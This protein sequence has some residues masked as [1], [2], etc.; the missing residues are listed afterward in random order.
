MERSALE[1]YDPFP[2]FFGE[3]R[4]LGDFS[5]SFIIKENENPNKGSWFK[6]T[7]WL[8]A[9]IID[10]KTN[11]IFEKNIDYS[12]KKYNE[13]SYEFLA[14]L[15]K[16]RKNLTLASLI[17]SSDTYCLKRPKEIGDSE[18]EDLK[19]DFI[20]RFKKILKEDRGQWLKDRRNN[21]KQGQKEENIIKD[22]MK[23]NDLIKLSPPLNKLHEELT[24]IIEKNGFYTKKDIRE[25]E[26]AFNV[27]KRHGRSYW[28]SLKKY[29]EGK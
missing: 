29:G 23:T 11:L 12:Y 3:E 26:Q 2:L 24:N 27:I 13:N 5:F 1:V 20:N 6:T 21:R 4:V 14:I 17:S 15:A 28:A 7:S 18:Y 10:N 19:T 16:E 9:I 22:I 25:L 8:Q